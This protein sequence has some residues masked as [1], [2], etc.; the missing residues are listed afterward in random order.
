MRRCPGFKRT[1]HSDRG[2]TRTYTQANCS[3]TLG[4]ANNPS[5]QVCHRDVNV[6][7]QPHTVLMVKL[8][9]GS[10]TKPEHRYADRFL[11]PHY[12]RHEGEQPM[13]VWWRLDVELPEG[14]WRLWKG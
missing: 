4:H 1:W 9:K 2:G 8:R 6:Q 5:W 13:R 7:G 14:L 12:L 3:V 10:G 11:T